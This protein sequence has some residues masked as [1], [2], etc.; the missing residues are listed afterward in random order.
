MNTELPLTKQ[1]RRL[2]FVAFR[3]QDRSHK[4]GS[5]ALVGAVSTASFSTASQPTH[6]GLLNEH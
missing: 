2:L 4:S 5:G 3:G 6:R 1:A